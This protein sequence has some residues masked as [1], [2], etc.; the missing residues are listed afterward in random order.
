MFTLRAISKNTHFL[1]QNSTTIIY[2]TM[3]QKFNT[4]TIRFCDYLVVFHGTKTKDTFHYSNLRIRRKNQ[5]SHKISAIV[6]C[7]LFWCLHKSISAI[8]FSIRT[9]WL[10]LK[11]ARNFSYCNNEA[12]YIVI[13]F[14]LCA[15]IFTL[16]RAFK[17]EAIR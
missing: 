2:I 13:H 15:Y 14:E 5:K 9:Y 1:K 7:S 17:T 16:S 12:V 3:N 11:W 6:S 10:S 8:W 4:S